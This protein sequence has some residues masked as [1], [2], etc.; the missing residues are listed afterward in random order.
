MATVY[1]SQIDNNISLPTAFDNTTEVKAEIVNQLRDAIVSI[2]QALGTNPASMYGTV[3]YRLSVLETEVSSG[4]A[5]SIQNYSISPSTPLPGQA[6]IWNGSGSVW[7][8]TTIPP[9][10][11]AGGDLSGTYA[12][13]T[14]I[15]LQGIPVSATAPT[16]NQILQFIGAQWTPAA[17]PITFT[18]G[19]DLSG[20][21]TSQTVQSIQHV[22]I[23]GTPSSGQV[24]TATSST[25]ADWQTPPTPPTGFTAGGDLGGTSTSQKVEGLYSHPL[26]STAPVQSAV[27][28][29]DG[30]IYDIRPLTADDILAGFT[31]NSFTGGSTVEIGATVT[32]PVF[33]ASYNHTPNS[34]Q[35]TNTDGI[36][37][38][39]VLSSPYTSGTVDGYFIHNATASTTFTLT[40]VYTSTKTATS[41]I[42]W[43]AR[44]FGG[45]GTAGAT[46]ATSGAGNTAVLVG[47]TGT[48]SS[49]GLHSSDIGQ[50]YGPFNPTSQNIYLLLPHTAS[51][52]T[53]KDQNGFTFAMNAP[54]TFSFTNQN[55]AVISMDLY[56]STNV[57]ST[58]FTITVET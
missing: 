34:A 23:S 41:L 13:Q 53:F 43:Y 46:S 8:P 28:V 33:T 16:T 20:S 45:L 18:A 44:S 35:I 54:T 49:E 52:H 15:G 10:F 24:L 1:P 12:N 19:G 57:L 56:Q 38:P 17:P 27:P 58:T 39:L 21:N 55:S 48:L 14:V 5:V 7:E 26:A 32:N 37:S 25:A 42:N 2:E 50:S 4:N 11:I 51:P 36:D 31:I 29:W 40:A 9:G 30:A 3:S 6:L 47:A 22:V